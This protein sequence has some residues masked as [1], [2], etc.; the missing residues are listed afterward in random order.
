MR[1]RCQVSASV[2]AN[3]ACSSG[4]RG[5]LLSEFPPKRFQGLGRKITGLFLFRPPPA[6][7]NPAGSTEN[8]G[9]RT[10]PAPSPAPQ[11]TLRAQERLRHHPAEVLVC[12]E[13]GT[14][15]PYLP[16]YIANTPVGHCEATAATAGRSRPGLSRSKISAPW[17]AQSRIATRAPTPRRDFFRAEMLFTSTMPTHAEKNRGRRVLFPLT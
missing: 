14:T 6:T 7:A 5:L 15:G 17:G 2:C 13:R 1:L 12:L 8:T 11:N 16:R 9:R 10:G 3:S 4:L